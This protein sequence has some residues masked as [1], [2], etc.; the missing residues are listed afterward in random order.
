MQNSVPLAEFTTYLGYLVNSIEHKKLNG[1][2][3]LK[4]TLQIT[5]PIAKDLVGRYEATITECCYFSRLNYENRGRKVIKMFSILD[6]SPL[7]FN[8]ALSYL[9]FS[10]SNDDRIEKSPEGKVPSGYLLY[11]GVHDTPLSLSINNILGEKCLVVSFRG[12]ISMRTVLKDLN[13][14]F[15]NLFELFGNDLFA[16]EF[17]EVQ[18]RGKAIVNPF[19]AHRGFVTGLINIYPIIIQRMKTLLEA[20]SDIK[21]VFITGHS[22]GGAYANIFGLAIAQMRK[23]SLLTMPDLHVITFGAPKTFTSYARNVFNKLLLEKHMTFDRITNRPRFPDPTMMTYDPIPLIPTHMDHPGFSILNP[24]IKTQSRTG[25]TKHVSELRNELSGI[26]S[27][28]GFFSKLISRNYNPLPDYPEFFKNFKDSSLITADEY[29][30]LLNTTPGGTIRIGM[31]PAGKLIDL[32]KTLFNAT[33]QEI[34]EVEKIVDKEMAKEVN[35]LK[36]APVEVPQEAVAD[37]KAIN[38]MVDKAYSNAGEPTV[39]DVK[40]GGSANSNTYKKQTVLEQPNHLVYSCS[41]ITAPVPLAGCHLGYMGIG[42]MGAGIN[43][44]SGTPGWRGYDKEA[45]LYETNGNWTFVSDIKR[46]GRKTRRNRR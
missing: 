18:E 28:A 25:R 5:S 33:P 10:K 46:G 37:V 32:I 36:E 41:Q 4:K 21:R 38:A 34:Q 35:E 44:G 22:L 8:K 24:E 19:G 6:Y 13:M 11:D 9:T 42:W 14:V 40:Q 45:V 23:K 30:K 20:H 17:K 12:T 43:A 29:S 3:L 27:K 1:Q 2:P 16:E 31:G 7:V 15:K 39:T 26:K